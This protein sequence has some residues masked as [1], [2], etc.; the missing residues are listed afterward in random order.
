MFLVL[1]SKFCLKFSNIAK[2]QMLKKQWQYSFTFIC[3]P[4]LQSCI[5]F[6]LNS[7]TIF[8]NCKDRKLISRLTNAPHRSPLIVTTKYHFRIH[9]HSG[10]VN[11]RVKI[12]LPYNNYQI[13]SYVT[14]NKTLKYNCVLV[15]QDQGNYL[16]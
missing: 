14:A 16:G 6:L 11:D 9:C 4:R 2:L 1:K 10:V 7:R 8:G 12:R 5:C 15:I 13:G 3:T